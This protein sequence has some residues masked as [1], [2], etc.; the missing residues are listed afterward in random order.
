MTCVLILNRI[1]S[2]HYDFLKLGYFSCF[3][4]GQKLNVFSAVIQSN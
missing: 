1:T 2:K 3:Q 4:R